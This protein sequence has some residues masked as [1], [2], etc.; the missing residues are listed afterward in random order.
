MLFKISKDGSVINEAH[1]SKIQLEYLSIL[2][3]INS[4]Y[5]AVLK[6]N[7]VGIYIRGSVSVGRAKPYISD[8]DSVAITHRNV[9]KKVLR[10]AYV[11]STKLQ[12]RFPFVTLVDMTILSRNKLM[13]DPEFSNLKIYLKTQ[14]VCLYGNDVVKDFEPVRPGRELAL[15]MYGDISDKLLMLER[16]FLAE[17]PKMLYL[18]EKRPTHFWCIWTMRTILRSALG[19]VMIKKPV[20]SQDLRTCAKVFC[21]Q[22]PSYEK[23]IRKAILWAMRPTEKPEEI[24]VYL[25]E[26]VPKYLKLWEEALN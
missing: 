15:A 13:N 6:D 18:G 10:E 25:R 24:I 3:I 11:F 23:Y 22:Y 8:I 2:K 9:T 17:G 4:Y 12:K 7:L 5:K 16:H 20:Y 21:S 26:F 1:L 19:L 14:S